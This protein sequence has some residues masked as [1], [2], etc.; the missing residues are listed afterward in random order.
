MWDGR[1]ASLEEQALAPVFNPDE[2]GSDPEELFARLQSDEFYRRTFA[3]LFPKE[4]IN[5]VV[6]GRAIAAFERTLVVRNTRFDQWIAGDHTALSASEVR[7]FGIFLD[8]DR[9]SCG[10][11]HAPPNFTDDGFHN[12]G[13]KSFANENPD[14]G[15]YEIRPVRLMR[16]AFKTPSLRNIEFTAPYFHDGSAQ[17]L[18]EVIEHYL[19]GGD[20]KDN[21]SPEMKDIDLDVYE[22]RDLIAFLRALTVARNSSPQ[23]SIGLALD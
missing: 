16:G 6:V 23:I 17:N 20:V 22:K 1:A 21:L 15:R 11:C 3:E 2:M 12:I 19:H 9:G 7:G 10:T 5:E 13:L 4:P 18:E 14:L 8:P